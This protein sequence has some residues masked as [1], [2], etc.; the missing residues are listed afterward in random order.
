LQNANV[1]PLKKI[2]IPFNYQ[3]LPDMILSNHTNN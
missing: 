3:G 2:S 1:K